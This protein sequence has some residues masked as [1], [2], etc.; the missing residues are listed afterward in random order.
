MPL[1]L[2]LLSLLHTWGTLVWPPAFRIEYGSSLTGQAL[3]GGA[4]LGAILLV[5][6]LLVLVGNQG[7]RIVRYLYLAALVAFIPSVMAVILK[8][9][10]G[11][12]LVYTASAFALVGFVQGMGIVERTPRAKRAFA[13]VLLI[14]GLMTVQ[15]AQ[16]WRSD[17][18]LF[19]AALDAPDP[20]TRNHLNLGIALFDDG[21]LAGALTQLNHDMEHAALDQKYYMLSLL[22]TAIRCE[23]LAEEYLVKSIEASPTYYSA[24]H[25]LA[26]LQAV[27]GRKDE[28][29]QTLTKIAERDPSLRRRALAQMEMLHKIRIVA[30]R[31]PYNSEW[32]GK[33]LKELELFKSPAQLNRLAGE[34]LRS[35]QLDLAE[36]LIRAALRVDPWFVGARL[37][38]AQLYMLKGD[39]SKAREIL[40]SILDTEPGEQR[41]RRLLST[42]DGGAAPGRGR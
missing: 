35:S 37:N 14:L 17:I 18:T 32:C 25:N 1:S 15:R 21:D 4:A 3:V 33:P 34:H 24:Y 38:F 41:A 13:C 11:S 40:Q 2:A 7:N 16:L 26:G 42:I 36:V 30:S 19:S 10:I 9:M 29:Q 23:G 12:R 31:I 5:W 27:Q 28:A 6:M 20:S 22:Y 8:S 39:K